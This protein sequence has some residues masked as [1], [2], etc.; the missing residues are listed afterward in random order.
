MARDP[1]GAMH[2]R[3]PGRLRRGASIEPTG[4]GPQRCR[5][6]ERCHGSERSSR[7]PKGDDE[8]MGEWKL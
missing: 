4:I 1:S 6:N 8:Y 3:Q 5:P 2:E 7:C